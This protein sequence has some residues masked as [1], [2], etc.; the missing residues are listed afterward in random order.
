MIAKYEGKYYCVD[1]S[2]EPV[3]I[4][5]YSPVEGFEESITRR[6]IVYYEKTVALDEIERIFDV[7]FSVNWDGQWCGV[8]YS[9]TKEIV[10][11]HTNNRDFA[12]AH[13][14]E[15]FERGTFECAVPADM[16]NEFRMWMRDVVQQTEVY[17]II[18]FEEFKSLWKQ[19]ISDLIPPR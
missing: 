3:D 14:M 5:C 11:L 19:M 1:M 13:G 17:T 6:G 2:T 8:F 4:W 16:F 15:E 7:G 18:S 12:I 9:A 10:S